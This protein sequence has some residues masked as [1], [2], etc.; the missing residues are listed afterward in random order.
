MYNTRHHIV[1]ARGT[2]Q[3]ITI[4][5]TSTRTIN[6]KN[7]DGKSCAE[8]RVK[9]GNAVRPKIQYSTVKY[10]SLAVQNY[11]GFEFIRAL[12]TIKIPT[13]APESER[14]IE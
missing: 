5:T 7:T 13:S 8:Q 4:Q 6:V 14:V 10:I 1:R 2:V 12:N 9:S 11:L 3:Y